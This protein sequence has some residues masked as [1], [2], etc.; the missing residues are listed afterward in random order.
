MI[1]EKEKDKK[2][3]AY[4]TLELHDAIKKRKISEINRLIKKNDKHD[5][6]LISNKR[7]D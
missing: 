1:K 2:K 6:G 3:V 4:S 5:K 7:G